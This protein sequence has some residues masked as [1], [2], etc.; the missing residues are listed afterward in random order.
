MAEESE[1]VTVFR[2]A[3]PDAEEQAEVAR[4]MLVSAGYDAEVFD[5]SAP[6]VPAGAFEVRVPR[7]Q[8]AGAEQL[9]D[10]QQD[11]SPEPLDLS[12]DLDMVT[13]FAS[14]APNAE[15]L[16]LEIRSILEAHDI[17]SVLVSG[18]MFP[19]LPYEVRVPKI[20]LDEARRAI[21]AAEDA[22]PPAAEEAERETET[23][24]NQ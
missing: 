24:E 4:E 8:Q 9:I 13:V 16:A 20:R 3:D 18:S 14:D 15:M 17:P 5:D 19:S 10:T 7:A 12:H 21:V 2:S 1:L 22:G 23:G 6:G 11:F